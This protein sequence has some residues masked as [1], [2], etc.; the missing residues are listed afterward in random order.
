MDEQLTTHAPEAPEAYNATIITTTTKLAEKQSK[1]FLEQVLHPRGIKV[2]TASFKRH[3]LESLQEYLGN[4]GRPDLQQALGK[5]F[6]EL[7]TLEVTKSFK[8]DKEYGLNET[9]YEIE[10]REYFLKTG[11]FL[12]LGSVC[13]RAQ[14]R[15]IV[16][17]QE[18]STW[19][20]LPVATNRR[21]SGIVPSKMVWDLVS[22]VY[23]DK[24]GNSTVKDK[25]FIPDH[26]Y[27]VNGEDEEERAKIKNYAVMQLPGFKLA[28]HIKPPYL[29]QESKDHEQKER[30]ARQYLSLLAASALHD[31][32]LLRSLSNKAQAEN[33]IALDRELCIY[34]M[35]CCADF[36]KERSAAATDSIKA[37]VGTDFSAYLNF[38]MYR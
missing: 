37:L 32:M 36:I 7:D 17:G 5:A 8:E 2:D 22:V 3:A 31:R 14:L 19:M 33:M 6:V 4:P 34:G 16:E 30:E 25:Y 26:I 27:A 21:E 38:S 15:M 11:R 24:V 13:R 23:P 35:T 10:Y 29:V 9:E 12:T 20:P 18:Q 1:L 28:K